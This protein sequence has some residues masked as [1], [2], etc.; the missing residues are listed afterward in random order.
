MVSKAQSIRVGLFATATLVLVAVVLIVFAGLRVWETSDH[1][2]IVFDSSVIGLEPGAVVYLNGI[3]VGTV[4]DVAVNRADLRKVNVAIKVDHGTPV[5]TDTHAM[6]QY[7]GITGLKV[8]DL[9]DGT[10]AAA[11]LP[12]GG[13]I[14][15]GVGMLD[16][17]EARAQAIVEQSSELMKRVS[18]LTDNL[19][20]VTE[21]ARLAATNF[22]ELS[23]SLKEMV[24]ENRIGLRQS[25]ATLRQSLAAIQSTATGAT[26]LLDGQV[27]QLLANAGD[28]VSTLKKLMT[29]NEGPLRA[30]V[31]DLREASRSF[32]ELARDVRQKPSRLLFSTAPAE[33]KLP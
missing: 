33:R 28:A 12:P 4:E 18:A 31:F 14:P 6:L 1:Y 19:I 24:D 32:K 2:R 9:R 5:R 10:I 21:P 29:A 25:L 16:K 11:P 22:A 20:A 26:E 7:A 17:L 23:G 15:A 30:A 8:I 13:E 27:S 3:K